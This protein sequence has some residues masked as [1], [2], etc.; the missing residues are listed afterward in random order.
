MGWRARRPARTPLATE[1]GRRMP[2]LQSAIQRYADQTRETHA[3][4]PAM[5]GL[6]GRIGWVA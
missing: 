3:L 6:A 4:K 1:R 2:G 5:E